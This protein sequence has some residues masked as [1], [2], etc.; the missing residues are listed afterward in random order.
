MAGEIFAKE[1]PVTTFT[2]GSTA[3]FANLVSAST[4]AN[5]DNRSTGPYPECYSAVFEFDCKW[6]GATTGINNSTNVAD[7][8]LVPTLD[9][10]NF[11]DLVSGAAGFISP[12]HYVAS[13]PATKT[14]TVSTLTRFMTQ[15]IDLLPLLYQPWLINQSG[16]TIGSSWALKAVVVRN[17]YT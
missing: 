4:D 6:L 7:L 5:F 14:P 2:N 1:F 10:T 15:Q 16:Q 8:Y 12:N 3:G 9:G 11:P 17:Q 13:F